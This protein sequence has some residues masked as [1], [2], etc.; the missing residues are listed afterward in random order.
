MEATPA[1][2]PARTEEGHHCVGRLDSGRCVLVDLILGP[3]RSIDP[4]QGGTIEFEQFYSF[5]VEYPAYEQQLQ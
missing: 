1:D 5:C 2:V 4:Y 3:Q